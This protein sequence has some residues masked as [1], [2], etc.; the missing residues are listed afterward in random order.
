MKKI[1][2]NLKQKKETVHDGRNHYARSFLRPKALFSAVD[3]FVLQ[4]FVQVVEVIA[5]AGDADDEVFVLFRV[6]LGIEEGFPVDDVELDVMAVHGE[7]RPDQGS[8]ASQ[9][10]R[11]GDDGRREFLIEQS[12]ASLELFQFGTGLDD[13]RRSVGISA[14]FRRNTIGQGHMGPAAVRA[15]AHDLAKVDV[16]RRRQEFDDRLDIDD[17]FQFFQESLPYIVI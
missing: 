10:F 15:G 3:D 17:V 8:Q 4:G 16:T 12:A 14:L 7:V 11:A 5:V 13:R 9:A 1:Y 6:A 2:N